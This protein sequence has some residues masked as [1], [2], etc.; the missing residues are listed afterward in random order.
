MTGSSAFHLGWGQT[1]LTNF[2]LDGHGSSGSINA[3]L[4]K[5]TVSRW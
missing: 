2:Q 4:D 5:V 1:L 3:Y